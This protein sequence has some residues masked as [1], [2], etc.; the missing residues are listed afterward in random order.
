MTLKQS[1]MAATAV[2]LL[3]VPAYADG[4]PVP[5]PMPEPAPPPEPAPEPEPAPLPEKEGGFYISAAG[6][7]VWVNDIDLLDEIDFSWIAEFDTGWAALGALGYDYG[8][9][10]RGEL[11]VGYRDNDGE[12]VIDGPEGFFDS[13]NV[14]ALTIMANGLYDYDTG[15]SFTPFIGFGL[16]AAQ[17]DGDFTGIF[18]DDKAWAF[19]YQFIGGLNIGMSD[20]MELFADYRYLATAGLEWDFDVIPDVVDHDEYRSHTVTGGI[21]VRF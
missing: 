13:A 2:A 4:G 1:L 11:E 15:S 18:S 8:N 14:K 21:R 10:V 20:R 5:E 19:A 3:A 6:G 16:G 9:G 12:I 17:V 7:A